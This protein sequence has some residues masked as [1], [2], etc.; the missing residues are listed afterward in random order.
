[1]RKVIYDELKAPNEKFISC[2]EGRILS[3]YKYF[4]NTD[5]AIQNFYYLL[6][7]CNLRYGRE[8][9]SAFPDP[10]YHQTL[11]IYVENK[12]SVGSEAGFQYIRK[13]IEQFGVSCEKNIF[14]TNDKLVDWAI[15]KFE[16]GSIPIVLIDQ[17]YFPRSSKFSIQ[18]DAVHALLLYG[19]DELNQVFYVC[20]SGKDLLKGIR[21]AVDFQDIQKAAIG[22]GFE[23]SKI[24]N[25]SRGNC[26][27][28]INLQES[29]K[30][31]LI[32]IE[33]RIVFLNVL[34][35]RLYTEKSEIALQG[36]AVAI[37]Y[38]VLP[39]F[40][41]TIYYFGNVL[42]KLNME[43][44]YNLHK[45]WERLSAEL[46]KFTILRKSE[47]SILSLISEIRNEEKFLSVLLQYCK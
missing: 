30:Y 1:V 26:N 11:E 10:W 21:Y 24:Q 32:S 31:E 5:D 47:Q 14:S 4:V 36:L 8:S 43:N 33:E 29:I 22:I 16:G 25:S 34:E 9:G 7:N 20:D 35:Q 2:L 41:K 15:D 40:K 19:V 42:P 46:I 6:C 37:K 13:Y 39:Y 27:E 23:I 18:R 17:F 44:I 28:N 38:K 3:A 45:K 12:Y